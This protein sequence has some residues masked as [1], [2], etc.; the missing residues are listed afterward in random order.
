MHSNANVVYCT[1]SS[2]LSEKIA[3]HFTLVT[4]K[5]HSVR[6]VG[7]IYQIVKGA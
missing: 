6:K 4:G 7:K 5:P 3:A 2:I 1:Y